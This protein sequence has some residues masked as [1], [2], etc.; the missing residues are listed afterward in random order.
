METFQ[1][2]ELFCIIE[3]DFGIHSLDKEYTI[4]QKM[5]QSFRAKLNDDIDNFI[6]F[7][8]SSYKVNKEA[9]KLMRDFKIDEIALHFIN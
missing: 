7:D 1:Q 3:E 4:A 8:M 2:L 6:L 5:K 9:Q